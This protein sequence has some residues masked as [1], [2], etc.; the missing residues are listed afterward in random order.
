M[1][2]TIL[3]FGILLASTPCFGVPTG[4]GS[5]EHD[6]FVEQQEVARTAT[7]ENPHGQEDSRVRHADAPGEAADL[8]Q[9]AGTGHRLRTEPRQEPSAI[10]DAAGQP[11]LGIGGVGSALEKNWLAALALL[12]SLANFAY[13]RAST[14]ESRTDRAIEH[15]FNDDAVN[16]ILNPEPDR[17]KALEDP[18]EWDKYQ[19]DVIKPAAGRLERFAAMTNPRRWRKEFYSMRLVERVASVPIQD[20]WNDRYMR[21]VVNNARESANDPTIYIEFETLADGMR[22]LD[23]V[24]RPTNRLHR[25]L[26]RTRVHRGMK[27]RL[28][29]EGVL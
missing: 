21:A 24:P 20:I 5:S 23:K 28:I 3:A 8:G 9:A 7:Q 14:K 29:A 1:K 22:R 19:R 11:R 13:T 4:E 25:A 27:R 15:L 2:V 10:R 26:R 18:E 17:K 12:L 16:R 6:D